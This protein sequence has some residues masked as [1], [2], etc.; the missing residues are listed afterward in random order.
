MRN[1]GEADAAAHR[2]AVE[3][4]VEEYIERRRRGERADIDDF[5]RRVPG[6]E[7]ESRLSSRDGVL[8]RRRCAAGGRDES[9]T[10]ERLGRF[11]LLRLIGRGGTGV[12]FEAA[13]DELDRGVALKI[14]PGHAT[15]DEREITRFHREFQAA[16]RLHHP[17]IVPIFGVGVDQ[18]TQRLAMQLV[19]GESLES[20]LSRR[21]AEQPAPRHERRGLDRRLRAREVRGHRD[22]HP[23][24]RDVGHAALHGARAFSRMTRNR[25]SPPCRAN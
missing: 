1:D 22:S 24:R 17:H 11:R 25:L 9:L 14:L 5:A 21:E 20:V 3:F 4:L 8:N 10:G 2:D 7:E 15:L 23:H 6:R 12:V 13:D 16:A 18:G 19:P